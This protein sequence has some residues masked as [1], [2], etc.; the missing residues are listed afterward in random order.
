MTLF[1]FLTLF[2]PSLSFFLMS[3]TS[4]GVTLT[5]SVK[6]LSAPNR[7]ILFDVLERGG[8]GNN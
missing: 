4:I 8:K 5:S 3:L 6:D 1:L 2:V 7:D